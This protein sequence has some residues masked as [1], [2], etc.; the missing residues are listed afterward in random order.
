MAAA[1][2]GSFRDFSAA[3]QIDYLS[4]DLRPLRLVYS[5]RAL[6]AHNATAVPDA[7]SDLGYAPDAD[8]DG[9]SDAREEAIGSEPAEADTDRDGIG[10]LVEDRLRPAGHDPLDRERPGDCAGPDPSWDEDGD[11]LSDCAE[12]AL[13]TDRTRVDSDG[14]ALP[15]G[16]ELRAGT[17]PRRDDAREDVDFDGVANGDEL[18]LGLDPW[19]GND[20]R[21]VVDVGYRYA[22][23]RVRSPDRLCFE[24]DVRGISL[25]TSVGTTRP[26]GRN[27]LQV[28]IAEG[29]QGAPGDQDRWRRARAC[30]TWI[31]PDYRDPA[32]GRVDFGPGEFVPLWEAEDP[33]AAK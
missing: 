19:S 4:F 11:G 33:C 15:D 7:G 14:D 31:D 30:A 6:L 18:H 20:E 29:L 26:V 8:G 28:W 1:G 13:G 5:L 23:R 2:C 12:A 24:F 21:N 27:D 16:L 10:D 17:D 9:I 32:D 3:E 22:S 25:V